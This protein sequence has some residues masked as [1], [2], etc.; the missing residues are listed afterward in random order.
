MNIYCILFNIGDIISLFTAVILLFTLWAMK[1]GNKEN[2]RLNR[3]EAAENTILKQIEFHNNLLKNISINIES[4]GDGHGT[5]N[6]PKDALGQEAFKIFYNRLKNIYTTMPG[7]YN[8]EM[9]GEERRI[10]DSFTQL[11]NEY[12]SL[13]GNYFKNLY[14]LVKYVNDKR[15]KY[16]YNS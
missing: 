16:F 15:I 3:V 5:P 13:F 11:Y 14:L 8:N 9:D 10:K 12:G 7:F 4:T 2:A 1:N 6:P